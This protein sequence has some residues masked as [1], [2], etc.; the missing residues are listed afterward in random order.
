MKNA[1]RWNVVEI[2]GKAVF[3]S[4][5]LPMVSLGTQDWTGAVMVH[6]G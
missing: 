3:L 6:S 1:F 5:D 4:R 2:E